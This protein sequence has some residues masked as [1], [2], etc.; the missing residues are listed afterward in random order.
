MKMIEDLLI[1]ASLFIPATI[2]WIKSSYNQ[3]HS[4]HSWADA[5]ADFIMWGIAICVAGSAITFCI[6]ILMGGSFTFVF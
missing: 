2:W 5:V 1:W 6:L 3:F 4:M